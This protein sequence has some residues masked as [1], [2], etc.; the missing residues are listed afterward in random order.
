MKKVAHIWVRDEVYMTV[1]G[2][3]PQD[4]KFLWDKF[5]I[6][7]DGHFFMPAYKLGRWDGKIRFF[8]KSGKVFMRFLPDIA[9]YLEKWGYEIELHDERKPVSLINTRLHEHWFDG[10]SQVPIKIRP[11]QIEAVNAGLEAGSGFVIAATGAG[12]CVHG[13][14]LLNI[15]CSDELKEML[16]QENENGQ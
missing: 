7:V 14:T 6:P 8:D 10:K 12:K 5:G 16:C 1:S 15:S 2:I 11:Y 3:E 13:D 9:M 4:H